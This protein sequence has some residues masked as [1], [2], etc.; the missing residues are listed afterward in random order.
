MCFSPVCNC[1]GARFED[2]RFEDDMILGDDGFEEYVKYNCALTLSER[3]FVRLMQSGQMSAACVFM[4]ETEEYQRKMLA[5]QEQ[6]KQKMLAEQEQRKQKMLA[7]QEQRKQ[8]MLAEQE[9]I[10]EAERAKFV[11]TCVAK[12]V[13]AQFVGEGIL[14]SLRHIVQCLFSPS[15]MAILDLQPDFMSIFGAFVNSSIVPKDSYQK[16]QHP[17]RPSVRVRG[18]TSEEIFAIHAWLKSSA[19]TAFLM[20]FLCR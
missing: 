18:Y 10:R 5:E 16:V 12:S 8:K 3:T 2:A 20:K 11:E 15:G 13:P 4:K 6:R 7:E 1:D 17:I 14:C 19:G 9:A